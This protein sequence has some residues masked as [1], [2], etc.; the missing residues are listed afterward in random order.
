MTQSPQTMIKNTWQRLHKK[1]AGKWLFSQIMNHMVPYSGSIR[2]KVVSL[3]PGQVTLQLKD[4]RKIRNHLHSIHAIALTNLGEY[5]SGLALYTSMPE[6][7]RGIVVKLETEYYKK[8]RGTLTAVSHCQ[9]PD[10]L[11]NTI[12]LVNTEIKD[13]NH[14]LVAKTITHWRLSPINQ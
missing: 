11:S 10:V 13:Q 4:K 14:E 5:C 1:P 3:A 9:C 8:A 2:A 12:Y 6:H 7:I